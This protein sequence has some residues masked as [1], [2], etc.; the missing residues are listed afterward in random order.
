VKK[1]LFLDRDGV[2]DDLV[3]QENGEWG[4]PLGPEQVRLLPGVIEALRLASEDGWLIFVVSNQPDAA[5]G[6]TTYETLRAAH[7]RLLA[8]LGDAPVTEFFYCY[9]RAEDRCACRKPEPFFVLEAA[10]RYEIDLAQSWFVGD[11]D[12]DIECGHRAGCR[13]ALLEYPYSSSRRGTQRPDWV[14]RD[15]GHFVR[16]LTGQPSKHDA[17]AQH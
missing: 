16:T 15:L 2:L 4:A 13:T 11:V 5:K 17:K 10:R 12:T 8:L 9:H 6:K 1:A 3:Q 14:C 7:E